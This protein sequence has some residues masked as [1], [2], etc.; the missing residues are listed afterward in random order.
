VS[1][2]RGDVGGSISGEHGIGIEKQNFMPWIFSA[3]AF[4]VTAA[5]KAAFNPGGRCN[6]G[7][8]FPT[9]KSCVPGEIVYHPHPIEERGLAQRL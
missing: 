5:V 2:D 6:P 9:A 8:V 3:A 7:K 4:E 1:P